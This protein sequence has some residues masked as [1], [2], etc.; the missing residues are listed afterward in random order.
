MSTITE[1]LLLENKL[2]T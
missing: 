1:R 2:Q